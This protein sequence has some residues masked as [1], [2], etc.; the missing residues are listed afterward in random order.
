[1]LACTDVVSLGGCWAGGRSF[2]CG[3]SYCFCKDAVV[4][5]VAGFA[6]ICILYIVFYYL[7]KYNS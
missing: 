2:A 5:A 6:R 4:V 7:E 1:M 3:F